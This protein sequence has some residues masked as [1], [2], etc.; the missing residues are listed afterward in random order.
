MADCR[1]TVSPIICFSVA[2][3]CMCIC[4]EYNCKSTTH[5]CT[6]ELDKCMITEHVINKIMKQNP[7]NRAMEE[8]CFT[9]IMKKIQLP[10]KKHYLTLKYLDEWMDN[11]L[12]ESE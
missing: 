6:C 3:R 8:I 12:D 1:C 7:M 9:Y 5:K 11:M 2:G 4:P 10:E